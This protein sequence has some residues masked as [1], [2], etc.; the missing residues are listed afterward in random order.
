MTAR[1]ILLAARMRPRFATT[2]RKNNKEREAK[3]RKAHASHCR[4]LRHG[5]APLQTRAH[6]RHPSA[7]RGALAFRRSAAALAPASERQDSAQAALH[8]SG[9]MQA[10]PAPSIALKRGTSHPGRNAGGDDTRTA[11]ERVTSPARRNRTRSAIRCV[12]RS[13][14]FSERDG[15]R[16][17]SSRRQ[18]QRVSI[19]ADESGGFVPRLFS[20]TARREFDSLALPESPLPARWSRQSR[21]PH[22]RS[23]M[24]NFA[25]KAPMRGWS[26]GHRKVTDQTT[27]TGN[28]RR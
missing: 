18:S 11:R 12:S 28:C 20:A 16:L 27:K 17:L 14:P 24:R 4:A 22:E 8:A 19:C 13:R 23:D 3:R 26:A 21:G 1:G 5:S 15:A 9:R 25:N 2:T 7:F 6:S 10:L